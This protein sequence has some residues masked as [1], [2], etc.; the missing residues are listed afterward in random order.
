MKL[1]TK[2]VLLHD[3]PLV[4]LSCAIVLTIIL[5]VIAGIYA[6]NFERKNS[7]LKRQLSE[8]QSLSREVVQI[9][10]VVESKEKRI[11]L[12]KSAGVV[13][14]L[15][16]ILTNL[17]LEAQVIKPL[18]RT[19]INEFSEENAELTLQGADLNSVVNLLYKI[20]ISPAPL[21]IKTVSIKSSFEDPDRFIVHLT[22]ALMSRG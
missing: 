20:D 2:R 4:L 10:A 9:K 11:G 12:Q 17:G 13:S 16:Q 19:K 18:A 8:M 15:E 14:T 1:L 22:I 3:T 7:T 6:G 21:K 5:T